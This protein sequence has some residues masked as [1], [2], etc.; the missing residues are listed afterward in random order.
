MDRIVSIQVDNKLVSE[1]IS[2]A[3][4]SCFIEL[5]EKI[6]TLSHHYDENIVQKS[7]IQGSFIYNDK[8]VKFKMGF[9]ISE[10]TRGL[11]N[12]NRTHESCID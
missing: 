12:D 2:S 9:K 7:E 10:D 11:K 3:A 1:K 5:L 6:D 4:K 8:V